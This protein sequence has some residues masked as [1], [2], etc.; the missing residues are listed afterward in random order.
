[1]L[2]IGYGGIA[3]A[4]ADAA[5]Q[6]RLNMVLEIF[7]LFRLFHRKYSILLHFILLALIRSNI[8]KLLILQ[9]FQNFQLY[10][11]SLQ[12]CKEYYKEGLPKCQTHIFI[13]QVFNSPL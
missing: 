2:H 12:T 1:M 11:D 7:L 4:G 9:L 3:Y 6:R 5:S 10:P 8:I 13:I